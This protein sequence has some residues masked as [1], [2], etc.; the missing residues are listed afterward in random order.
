L[1]GDLIDFS[2]DPG[3]QGIGWLSNDN[4]QETLHKIRWGHPGTG[5]PSLVDVGLTDQQI[6]DILAYAQTLP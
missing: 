1:D 6:G 4:P 2:G 3:V 5:M